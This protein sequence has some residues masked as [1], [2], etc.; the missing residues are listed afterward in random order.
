MPRY[1]TVHQAERLLPVI[2]PLME[3]AMVLFRALMQAGHELAGINWRINALGGTFVNR[4]HI[5]R[6]RNRERATA[7]R[8]RE[9]IEEIQSQGCQ[10]KDLNLGLVDFPT[11][12][13]GREVL[14]CWKIDE[15][16]IAYWHEVEAGF[17][18][19]QPIDEEFLQSHRGETE[20]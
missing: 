15:P 13:R 14:L 6:L 8:L 19:R 11:R 10:V 18:G 5:T 16:F 12:Y 7:D 20:H 2:K 1:F 4:Q 3:Q 9:L 17:A